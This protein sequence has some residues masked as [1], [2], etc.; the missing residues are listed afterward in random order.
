MGIFDGLVGSVVGGVAS[1]VGGSSSNSAAKKM[2]DK[3]NEMS[4]YMSNT[5]HQREVKDLREAGLNPILSAGGGSGASTPQMQSYDPKN[6]VEPAVSSA[7]KARQL[8]GALENLEADTKLKEENKNLAQ[9]NRGLVRE[10]TQKSIVDY[11]KTDA[12]KDLIK[13]NTATAMENFKVA[14]SQ[15]RIAA[16]EAEMQEFGGA[17]L[18]FAPSA[19]GSAKA[20]GELFDLLRKKGKK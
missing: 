16:V 20:A 6:I 8:S 11:W 3:N 9:D 15:A 17:W 12:E 4:L 1:L 19:T 5:A 18:K 2:A 13:V 14:Q 7:L 10:Q